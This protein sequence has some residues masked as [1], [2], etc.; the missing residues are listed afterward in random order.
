MSVPSGITGGHGFVLLSLSL[1]LKF[2]LL[3]FGDL[4]AMTLEF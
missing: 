1:S 4:T 3:N 2:L